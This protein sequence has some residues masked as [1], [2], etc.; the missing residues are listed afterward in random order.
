MS[1]STN[2]RVE[3]VKKKPRNTSPVA[4]CVAVCCSVCSVVQCG[5]VWRS[6]V[7]CGAV[8]YSVLQCVKVRSSANR[9]VEEVEKKPRKASPVA[10]CVAVIIAVSCSVV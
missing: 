4:V 2:C 6:M 8:R 7:Q 5:A 10:A 9:R 3:E 1:S